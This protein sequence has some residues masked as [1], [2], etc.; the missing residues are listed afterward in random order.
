ML[1]QDDFF[2]RSIIAGVG[3]AAIAGP[4]GCLVVWQRLAYLGDAMAHSALLGIALSLLF[5]LN[6]MVGVFSV[7]I[8]LALILARVG[9]ASI[10]SGDSVLG[11][12]S[13]STLALGLVL[14]SLMYWIRVDL[15]DYLLGNIIAVRWIDIYLILAG[16]CFALCILIWKW[17]DFISLTVDDQIAASEGLNPFHI[18]SLLMVLLAGTIAIAI[19]IVGVLLAVSLLIIP[20]ATARQVARTPEQMAVFAAL[21]GAL[22]VIG[23]LSMSLQVDTPAGPSIVVAA[24]IQ[25]LCF[26]S[27]SALIRRLR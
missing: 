4:L 8:L 25:F 1:L 21:L 23:G 14:I 26:T 13:H 9:S 11:I 2:I 5:E 10:L 15:I 18:R 22:A 6:L 7:C 19:K 27:V 24:L 12:M 16:G 20:A 17:S 3:L